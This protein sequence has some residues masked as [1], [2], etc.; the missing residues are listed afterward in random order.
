MFHIKYIIIIAIFPSFALPVLG[1]S[2]DNNSVPEAI[3]FQNIPIV[4]TATR[5]EQPILESPSTISVLTRKDLKYYG[6]TSFSDIL[7]NVPGVDIMS[8][9]AT[10]RNVG[11]RGLN[12]LGSGK[13]LSLV[14]GIPIYLDFYGLTSWEA[15]PI[16]LEEIER[17]EIVRGPGSALYGANALDGV[18]NI[19]TDSSMKNIGTMM[20]GKLN[21]RGKLG[22]SIIHGNQNSNF[23]YKTSLG[24]DSI[25][26]WDDEDSSDEGNRRL[27]GNLGYKINDYSGIRLRGG[28]SD[29]QGAVTALPGFAPIGYDTIEGNLRAEYIRS[30]LK[31]HLLYRGVG[32]EVS[33]NPTNLYKL[34]NDIID[35]DFQHSFYPVSRNFVTWGI[36]YKFT[37][38]NSGIMESVYTQNLWAIYIQDQIQL[39]D[40]LALTAGIRYD[41]H[42]LSGNNFSPRA[43]L[44]Y[45]PVEGHAIRASAGRAFRNPSYIHSYISLDYLLSTPLFPTPIGVRVDGNTELFPEQIL[46]FEIGYQGRFGDRFGGKA[47]SFVN[48]FGDMIYLDMNRFYDKDALFP[49]SPGGII[50]SLVTGANETEDILVRG[51]EIAVEALVANWL[52]AHANYSYQFATNLETKEKLE[53]APQHKF[54]P[55]LRINPGR[56]FFI[57]IFAN[58]VGGLK[59]EGVEIDSYIMLNSVIS[60]SFGVAEIGLSISNLLD[61][62]H[63]EHPDGNEIGRTIILNLTYQIN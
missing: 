9:S 52:S 26:G 33:M 35:S 19:I 6:V 61:N 27:N 10:D 28:I 60:Y 55:A 36:Y 24:W 3:L 50:P 13:I 42:P 58:Y 43:S 38:I 47:V 18:I 56:N 14:D 21:H 51:A 17:I 20:T 59:T 40:S 25:S 62:R 39:S 5:V 44:V 30:D 53:D 34:R 32:A 1:T 48:K 57:S 29:H 37:R 12:Q 8:I 46:S 54:S 31:L 7:R 22:G 23:D 2:E 15:L 41:R 16:S 45:S 63:L 49:G 11:M 4:V